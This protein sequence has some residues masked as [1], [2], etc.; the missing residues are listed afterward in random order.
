MSSGT[1][2]FCEWLLKQ[3]RLLAIASTEYDLKFW[4]VLVATMENVLE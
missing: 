3:D 2:A 1:I 4:C